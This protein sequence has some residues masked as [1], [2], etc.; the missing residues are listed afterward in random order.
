MSETFLKTGRV[1]EL[2]RSV[3]IRY[4]ASLTSKVIDKNA[5]QLISAM[6]D[7][8]VETAIVQGRDLARLHRQNGPLAHW[9]IRE[10]GVCASYLCL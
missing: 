4:V 2:E 8:A 10:G 3:T 9:G 6:L 1:G 7:F 5:D